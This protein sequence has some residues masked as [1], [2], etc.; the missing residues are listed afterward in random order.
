MIVE[1]KAIHAITGVEE[2]QV[3]NYLKATGMARGLVLN[4]GQPRLQF[5][6]FVF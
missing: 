2:A 4:F 1:L 6:R 3:L 5:K